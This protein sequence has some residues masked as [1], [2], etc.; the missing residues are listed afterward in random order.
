M[1][2]VSVPDDRGRAGPALDGAKWSNSTRNS[3]GR[4]GIG[5]A[6][7]LKSPPL[8]VGSPPKW[9]SENLGF[10]ARTSI[11]LNCNTNVHVRRRRGLRITRPVGDSPAMNSSIKLQ[12]F[13]SLAPGVCRQYQKSLMGLLKALPSLALGST[14][15]GT[16]SADFKLCGTA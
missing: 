8:K 7:K 11:V 2:R 16:V 14:S 4:S 9:C 6:I 1:A 13:C 3:R 15:R 10:V 12:S 5:E